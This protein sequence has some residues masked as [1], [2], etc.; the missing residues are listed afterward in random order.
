MGNAS[1]VIRHL[2]FL[3]P[4]Q[5]KKCAAIGQ[6][7]CTD[8]CQAYRPVATQAETWQ[9]EPFFSAFTQPGSLQGMEAFKTQHKYQ[10]LPGESTFDFSDEEHVML[11]QVLHFIMLHD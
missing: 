4:S 6:V 9:Q 1:C 8:A 7:S 3:H 11:V 10:I 5:L 2:L